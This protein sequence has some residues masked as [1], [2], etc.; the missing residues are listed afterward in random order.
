MGKAEVLQMQQ[1]ME[2]KKKQ[3]I[4]DLAIT[5]QAEKNAKL[6]GKNPRR[7]NKS[8]I[9]VKRKANAE[10]RTNQALRE[11]RALGISSRFNCICCIFGAKWRDDRQPSLATPR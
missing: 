9:P 2:K 5:I 10:S 3:L 11:R 1:T 7:A 4:K 8:A 6:C